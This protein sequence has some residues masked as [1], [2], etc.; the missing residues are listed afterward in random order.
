MFEGSVSY[1]IFSA[2]AILH[3]RNLQLEVL[4]FAQIQHTKPYRRVGAS[5]SFIRIAK[6]V[7]CTFTLCTLFFHTSSSQLSKHC[8][9]SLGI[10]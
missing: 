9:G 6:H 2:E 1:R 10:R 8:V 7:F 4:E 3:W 5:I